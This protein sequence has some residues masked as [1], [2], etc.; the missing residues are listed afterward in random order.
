MDAGR[1][2]DDCH[3]VARGHRDLAAELLLQAVN[4]V[5]GTVSRG[6]GNQG[7]AEV[8]LEWLM[9]RDQ[10]VPIDARTCIG[11]VAGL[12]LD[13][14][15]DECIECFARLA[16]NEPEQLAQA[17]ELGREDAAHAL[18]EMLRPGGMPRRPVARAV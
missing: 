17:I 13:A 18:A 16:V 4:S 8:Q 2:T 7:D 11:V 14:V 10:A 12:P 15:D 6:P 3:F 9:S 5:A 1:F